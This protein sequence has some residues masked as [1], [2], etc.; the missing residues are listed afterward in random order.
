MLIQ[1]NINVFQ[2]N[3]TRPHLQKHGI[4]TLMKASQNNSLTMINW[5]IDVG[6]K[7]NES[8][9]Y[10]G[11]KGGCSPEDYYDE[12]EDEIGVYSLAIHL[13][14]VTYEGEDVRNRLHRYEGADRYSFGG[15]P[16]L[17]CAT[18]PEAVKLLLAR[19]AKTDVW[20]TPAQ[21]THTLLPR[22]VLASHIVLREG[23]DRDLIVRAL[24]Q[25]GANVNEACYPCFDEQRANLQQQQQVLVSYWPSVIAS[26]NVALASEL[27]SKFKANVNWPSVFVND[28]DEIDERDADIVPI[29]RYGYFPV[30]LYYNKT[31]GLGSTVRRLYSFYLFFSV[32][33]HSIIYYIYIYFGHTA[34]AANICF[35]PLFKF[36]YI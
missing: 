6:C 25:H 18:T 31:T 1:K 8:F 20:Y 26:G 30:L 21:Q 17:I 2:A 32:Y 4:T 14:K 33:L 13:G 24:I 7:I 34:A 36:L 29:H 5:L 27:V 9:T 35:T 3:A 12:Y 22:T 10:E 16:A 19:G 11:N 28:F 15:A 23:A